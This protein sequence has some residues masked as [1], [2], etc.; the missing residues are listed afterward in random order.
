M[1]RKSISNKELLNIRRKGTKED[2]ASEV[3]MMSKRL[4]ERFRQ[5]ERKSTPEK[6]IS[7]RYAQSELGMEKPRFTESQSKLE[8]MEMHDLYMLA[9]DI[10]IKLNAK[11]S[12]LSGIKE[13]SQNRL[14]GALS[15]RKVQEAF[16]NAYEGMQTTEGYEDIF[17]DKESMRKFFEEMGDVLSGKNIPSDQIFEIYAMSYSKGI[18]NKALANKIRDITKKEKEIDLLKLKRW[19][20]NSNEE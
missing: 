10:N 8:N 11:T 15:S 2:L 5:I 6:N 19:L 13:A 4:N 17:M 20:N 3:R 9:L 18:S 16:E 1:K 14:E 12:T 7:Y